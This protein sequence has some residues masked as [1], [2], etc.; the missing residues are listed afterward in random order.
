[1]CDVYMVSLSRTSISIGPWRLLGATAH[2]MHIHLLWRVSF[3]TLVQM[4][5]DQVWRPLRDGFLLASFTHCLTVDQSRIVAPFGRRPQPPIAACQV[6]DGE[7]CHRRR[8]SA[9]RR[10]QGNYPDHEVPTSC[11]VPSS[12]PGGSRK[13]STLGVECTVKQGLI[14]AIR[15][16]RS[17]Y[18]PPWAPGMFVSWKHTLTAVSSSCETPS[19][20]I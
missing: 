13:L 16:S 12:T 18:S 14:R 11:Q 2:R 1:M 20:T 10:A 7:P 9:P 19:S 5:Q 3:L 15:L 6:S 8:S 4:G 17:C